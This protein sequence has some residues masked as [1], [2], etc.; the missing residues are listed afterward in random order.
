MKDY[1]GLAELRVGALTNGLL[2][3]VLACERMLIRCGMRFPAG[4]SRLLIAQ[5][6]A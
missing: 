4:G 1:A 3:A 6:S 2:A 5:R